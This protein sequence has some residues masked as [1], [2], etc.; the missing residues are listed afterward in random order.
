MV[1]KN[2]ILIF[3]NSLDLDSTFGAAIAYF[4]VASFIRLNT[5]D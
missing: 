1:Y 3:Y 5:L 4:S 2:K